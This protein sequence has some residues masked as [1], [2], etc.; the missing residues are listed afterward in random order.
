M[1]IAV[2]DFSNSSVDTI[3]VADSFI[4]K[5]YDG[6]IE[7]FLNFWCG[8]PTSNCEWMAGKD[9]GIQENFGLTVKDFDGDMV[10]EIPDEEIE[11]ACVHCKTSLED[12]VKEY[13]QSGVCMAETLARIPA[14]GLTIEEAFE[15]Y[16]KVMNYA[17]GDEFYKIAEG[18]TIKLT[19]NET[20]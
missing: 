4:D 19:S 10:I 13:S 18:E 20:Y 7:N 5:R 8:Y 15:L 3:Y 16:I 17:E 14:N 9:D 6:E 2:L 11:A 1:K 12:V